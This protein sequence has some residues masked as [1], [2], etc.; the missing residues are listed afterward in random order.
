VAGSQ[1]LI[2][3]FPERV[4]HAVEAFIVAPSNRHA[5]EWVERWPDWPFTALILVGPAG[6]GKT[7]LASL[8]QAKSGAAS[9]DLGNS[10]IEQA[11]ALTAGGQP[12]LAEDCDRVLDETQAERALLQ[13]YNLAKTAGSRLLLTARRAPSQWQLELPDL[14]S[15]LNSAMVVAIDPPDDELL[16]SVAA[17]LFG[18]KQVEVGEEVI[19]YLLSRCERTVSSLARA[20]ETLNTVSQTRQRPITVPMAREVLFQSDAD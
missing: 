18:D 4:D 9:I 17:K 3:P 14:K 8:W 19:A 20:V 13:L 15:R 11:A 7:H 2:F 6:C 16:R 1:Q 5:F 12:I 10:G